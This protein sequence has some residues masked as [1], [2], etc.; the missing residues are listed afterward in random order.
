MATVLVAGTA[1][2]TSCEKEG[3]NE[4]ICGQSKSTSSDLEYK[5]M[6]G[7]RTLYRYVGTNIYFCAPPKKNCLDEIVVVSKSLSKLQIISTY[8]PLQ[9]GE[10]FS[11][12]GWQNDILEFELIP[13]ITSILA[14]GNY[15]LVE[16]SSD[17]SSNKIFVVTE[18]SV[19]NEGDDIYAAIPIVVE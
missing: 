19:Y 2:F 1:L 14:T 7:K 18:Q 9:I 16:L 4:I 6:S 10:Y 11:S 15:Y 17:T 8:T 13:E 12:D 3:S 5:P